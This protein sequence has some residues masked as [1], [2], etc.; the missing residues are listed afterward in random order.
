MGF[1]SKKRSVVGET[2]VQGC[3]GLSEASAHRE[4]ASSASAYQKDTIFAVR[5]RM[6]QRAEGCRETRQQSG[7]LVLIVVDGRVALWWLASLRNTFA[8]SRGAPSIIGTVAQAQPWPPCPFEPSMA[9]LVCA[10]HNG[11][12]Q[13]GPGS[14][15]P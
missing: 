7:L 12:L 3:S 4:L 6:Q 14:I 11:S 8:R 1:K 9:G 15:V 13:S 10:R 5:R 2:I